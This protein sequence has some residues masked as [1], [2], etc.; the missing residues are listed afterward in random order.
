MAVSDFVTPWTV[1]CQAPH[2]WDFSGKNIGV[3]C[4]SL[5]RGILPTQGSNPG[6]PYCRRILY[7]LSH[8]G[9]PRGIINEL[10][11][12]KQSPPGWQYRNMW[13]RWNP[14]SI[15][16]SVIWKNKHCGTADTCEFYSMTCRPYLRGLA[17]WKVHV[18][19]WVKTLFSLVSICSS[20]KMG[21]KSRIVRKVKHHSHESS[22]TSLVTFLKMWKNFFKV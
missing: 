16:F 18:L 5:L 6:L 15:L 20:V 13:T 22:W 3:G 2:P 8:K 1:A 17:G 9:S 7:H 12:L 21:Y 14:V 19:L 10:S 11:A 4:H